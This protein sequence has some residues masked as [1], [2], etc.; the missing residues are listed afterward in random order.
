[1]AVPLRAAQAATPCGVTLR[2][3]LILASYDSVRKVLDKGFEELGRFFELGRFLIR[4]LK[5]FTIGHQQAA[6]TAVAVVSV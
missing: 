2:V 1:M 5:S 3:K 6:T 4:S